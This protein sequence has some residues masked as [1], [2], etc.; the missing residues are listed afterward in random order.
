MA[1]IAE[2]TGTGD[3][4]RLG[5]GFARMTK[6]SI[7]WTVRYDEVLVVLEGQITARTAD[8]DLTANPQDCIWLPAGT[9]LTYI[10]ENTLVFYAIEPANWAENAS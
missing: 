8:G 10:A 2:V 1:S 6:A 7:P 4:T 9:Q 3:G 5:T